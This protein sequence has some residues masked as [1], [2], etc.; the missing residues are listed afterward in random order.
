M[1]KNNNASVKLGAFPQRWKSS[2]I[3]PLWK[4]EGNPKE[5]ASSYRPVALLSAIGR[6]LEGIVAE[7][8]DKYAEDRGIAHIQVHG[9]R[10]GRGVG[11]GMLSLW[12]DVLEETGMARKW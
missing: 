9:F 12:E 3:K 6:L 7:R 10:K 2:R 1:Q 11:T 8:M 5:K 4:G